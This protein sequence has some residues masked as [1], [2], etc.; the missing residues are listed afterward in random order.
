MLRYG[1]DTVRELPTATQLISSL[2]M[3]QEL[4]YYD[5]FLE[6]SHLYFSGITQIFPMIGRLCSA[7]K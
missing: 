4:G 1:L 7:Y 6:F 2:D 3:L 5:I